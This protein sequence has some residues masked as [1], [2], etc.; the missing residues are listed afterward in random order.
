MTLPRDREEEYCA[1]LLSLLQDQ[2][3]KVMEISRSVL[4]MIEDVMNEVPLKDIE[5]KY[6]AILKLDEEE[7]N[8]RRMI[9]KDIANVGALLTSKE[10]FIRLMNT[11]EKIADTLEGIA[12]RL[13]SLVK[14]KFKINKDIFK[15]IL[16]LGEAVHSI[17][18][19]LREALLSVALD[20][21][22]FMKKVTEIDNAER[23]IDDI[24]RNLSL[25]ILQSDMKVGHMF[26]IR[27]IVSMLE[28][29]ADKAEESVETLRTLSLTVF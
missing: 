12:Y 19:K 26:L 4:L 7:R 11:L 1:R 2:I 29:I 15:G 13:V 9:E 18:G 6:D 17:L 20:S 3:R 5:A 16:Q 27:E 10:D 22:T 24:Y 28:D 25:V 21:E 23:E 8:I 14:I